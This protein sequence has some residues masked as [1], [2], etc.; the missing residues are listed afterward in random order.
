MQESAEQKSNDSNQL[1]ASTLQELYII[2]L[3]YKLSTV[4]SFTKTLKLIQQMTKMVKRELGPIRVRAW[5]A[6]D[7]CLQVCYL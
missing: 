7:I 5:F 2:L 3:F 1:I 4:C 6:Y